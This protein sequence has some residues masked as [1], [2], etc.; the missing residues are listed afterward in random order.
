LL[1][2]GN[3]A[4]LARVVFSRLHMHSSLAVDLTKLYFRS[5]LHALRDT[6]EVAL[7][8]RSDSGLLVLQ[9][10][11]NLPVDEDDF[12]KSSQA[13][14]RDSKC[15]ERLEF[16]NRMLNS[17]IFLRAT[18]SMMLLDWL[19]WSGLALAGAPFHP[20]ILRYAGL[21]TSLSLSS[22]AYSIRGLYCSNRTTVVFQSNPRF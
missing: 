17:E 11:W 15:Y 10:R 6:T 21:Q 5:F 3:I 13:S 8:R 19:V 2:V 22:E 16:P 4:P 7:E 20:T 14:I 1:S 9:H 12:S 18:P